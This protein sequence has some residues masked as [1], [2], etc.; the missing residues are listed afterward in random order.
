MADSSPGFP[1]TGDTAVPDVLPAFQMVR[2]AQDA[3]TRAIESLLLYELN[4]TRT[5]V[6]K[7]TAALQTAIEQHRAAAEEL[8]GLKDVLGEGTD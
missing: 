5:N 2:V 3:E 1:S 4:P 7:A 6:D 8:T